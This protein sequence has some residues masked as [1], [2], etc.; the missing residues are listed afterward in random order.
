M[1]SVVVVLP[2][3][4]WAMM[5]IFLVRSSTSDHFADDVEKHF[6]V[7]NGN[8]LRVPRRR[9]A[10]GPGFRANAW[11]E[12]RNNGVATIA[13]EKLS[14][15]AAHRELYIKKCI[16]ILIQKR[17]I[18]DCLEMAVEVISGFISPAE[19]VHASIVRCRH[20]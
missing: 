17:I 15:I 7:G 13:I 2:A 1:R 20:P 18:P 16:S 12:M 9:V 3:S 11:G 5:P 19:N 14:L 10:I 4:I 8:D 6:R